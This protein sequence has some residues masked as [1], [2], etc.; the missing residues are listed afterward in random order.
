MI[1]T[2]YSAYGPR[3]YE[4]TGRKARKLVHAKEAKWVV[5]DYAVQLLQ[6]LDVETARRSDDAAKWT[7]KQ[8]NFADFVPGGLHLARLD[9]QRV[10]V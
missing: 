7:T 9:A 4:T 5:P 3:L 10:L 8:P 2:V 6:P 1:V